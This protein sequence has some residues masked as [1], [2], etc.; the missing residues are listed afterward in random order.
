[1][2]RKPIWDSVGAVLCYGTVWVL[3]CAIP[4]TD[5]NSAFVCLDTWFTSIQSLVALQNST[6]FYL[7]RALILVLFLLLL[8][9]SAPLGAADKL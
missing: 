6:P 1:M 2:S 5:N 8:S 7:V 4:T 3:C 9:L